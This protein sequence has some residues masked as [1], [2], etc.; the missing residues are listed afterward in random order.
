MEVE[1]MPHPEQGKELKIG[2]KAGK[3]KQGG[4]I[5]SFAAPIIKLAVQLNEVL[6]CGGCSDSPRKTP[7]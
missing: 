2:K 3:H 1:S 5:T 7:H 6:T 4:G